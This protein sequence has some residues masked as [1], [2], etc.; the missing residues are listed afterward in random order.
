V[1]GE[2]QA[3]TALDPDISEEFFPFS[4]LQSEANVLIFPNLAAA[5]IAYK[6]LRQFASA[7]S[8]GPILM[9]MAKPVAVLQKGFNVEEV[10]T[11]S[12][13]AVHDAQE[14]HVAHAAVAAD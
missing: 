9:G 11:M 8:V 12:A 2:M 7:R 5:N 3:D 10:I 13:V 1:D 6:L 14:G 4:R